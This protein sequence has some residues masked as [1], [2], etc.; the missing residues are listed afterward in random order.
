MSAALDEPRD[1]RML[2]Q[3]ED[4]PLL[5]ETAD[6]SGRAVLNELDGRPLL[7]LAVGALAEEHDAHAPLAD[8]PHDAP[9]ADAVGSFP[10]GREPGI[11]EQRPGHLG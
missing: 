10:D 2:Q 6:Q 3:R 7:E 8:R 5:E 4:P 1:A 11:V 9:G